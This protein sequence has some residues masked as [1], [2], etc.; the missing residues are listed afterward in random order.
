MMRLMAVQPKKMEVVMK[1]ILTICIFLLVTVCIVSAAGS[2]EAKQEGPVKLIYMTEWEQMP[3]FNKYFAEKGEEFAKLYPDECSGVEVIII[4]YSGYEAKFLSGFSSNQPVCDFYKGMAHVWAGLYN[5]AEPMP[6][7]LADRLDKELAAYL[8]PLGIYDG[9]RYGYPV[10]SG[11]FQQLYI[12]VDMFRAAGLD[13]NKPPKDFE[14]L[15][16]YAKK[17]VKYDA[18]GN[19]EVAGFALRYSGEGQG[20]A[21]K[22]LTIIH[23]FGGK[24]FDV[25]SRTATGYVNSPESIKGLEWIKRVLDEKVTSL[26]VG[27]PETAFGQGRA[28]MIFRESWVSGWLD[29]N[30]PN[31]NYKI[32]PV[33]TQKVA[34]GGGNLFPWVN[35]VY[36]NSP[37]K[38][39]AWKFLDFLLTQEDDLEQNKRQ[40]MLPIMQANYDTE[41]VKN[42]VDFNSVKE[43]L[44]R[45]AGPAY[46]YYI[47]EMN[48]LASEFGT[49][50]QDVMYG[51]ATP[52]AALDKA[53]A[54]MDKILK[55]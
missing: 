40:G 41:Y 8:T 38:E 7:A 39:L 12:N 15:L 44:S 49:A 19:V 46:D 35:L 21:D 43:V 22:N 5:Y 36:S 33:P 42:R 28:A 32:Y 26:E 16:Q 18:K 10:E 37:N 55:K 27:I 30:A 53:A 29:A 9:V 6:K 17:L 1:K 14:E 4:P 3:E 20:V 34:V 24:M 54:N 51:R 52:K 13:P 31:I 45:G 47:A 48:Q 11:N 50:I 23:A 2:R 25:P